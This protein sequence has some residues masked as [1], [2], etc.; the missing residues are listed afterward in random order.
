MSSSE[1][2][3]EAPVNVEST[4]DLLADVGE[5]TAALRAAAEKILALG[6][7]EPLPKDVMQDALTA[8][9]RMYTVSHQLGERWP[10]FNSART[11]PPTIVMI[12]TTAMMRSV[13]V[14]LFELGM[15][16]AWADV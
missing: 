11:M 4:A 9:T 5:E 7:D 13:N 1:T 12:M 8:L 2:N 6:A 10:P 15:W 16:Q 3:Q 14:E